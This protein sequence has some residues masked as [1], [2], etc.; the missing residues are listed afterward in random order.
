LIVFFVFNCSVLKN[1]VQGGSY[2]GGVA[3]GK[4]HGWGRLTNTLGE[5]TEGNWIQGLLQQ[6]S[7]R[8]P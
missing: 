7:R 1:G 3:D 6:T 2:E 5:V 8:E 4:Y